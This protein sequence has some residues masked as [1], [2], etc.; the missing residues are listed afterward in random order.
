MHIYIYIYI[1]TCKSV[2]I[3][4]YLRTNRAGGRPSLN[5]FTYIY[6]YTFICIYTY[7]YTHTH[8][9]VCLYIRTCGRRAGV[10]P[11]WYARARGGCNR[12]AA[13]GTCRWWRWR[14][15]GRSGRR[16]NERESGLGLAVLCSYQPAS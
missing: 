6:V 16:L 13:P 12:S 7:L 11:F 5:V 15:A 1:Y 4:P 10:R 3:Y 14:A 2:H 9:H 8:M